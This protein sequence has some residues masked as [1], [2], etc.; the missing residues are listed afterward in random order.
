MLGAEDL[1]AVGEQRFQD[2]DRF[3]AAPGVPVGRGEVAA[4][5]ERDWVRGSVHGWRATAHRPRSA[6]LHIPATAA[7]APLPPEQLPRI[8]VKISLRRSLSG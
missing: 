2:R 8:E 5:P 7:N 3:T 6:G 4:G 1:L